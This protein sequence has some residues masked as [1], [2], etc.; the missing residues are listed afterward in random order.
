MLWHR[1]RFSSWRFL[2]LIASG[3]KHL[4]VRVCDCGAT[5]TDIRPVDLEVERKN[6]AGFAGDLQGMKSI[7][8]H[9]TASAVPSRHISRSDAESR[10]RLGVCRWLSK[11]S[12]VAI[13]NQLLATTS[14]VR[15]SGMRSV[16][17]VTPSGGY[18]GWQ[19]RRNRVR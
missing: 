13:D 5:E 8:F 15:Q 2:D 1:H 18:L 7:A 3:T 19:M 9:R 11:T 16:W 4:Y 17:H 6:Y 14:D 10:V 12:V